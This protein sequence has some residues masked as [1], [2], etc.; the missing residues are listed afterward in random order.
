MNKQ[1][2]REVLDFYSKTDI[3]T[4]Y[5]DGTINEYKLFTNN[6]TGTIKRISHFE[7]KGEK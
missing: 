4:P 1:E 3:L 7:S 5:I 2:I 6:E